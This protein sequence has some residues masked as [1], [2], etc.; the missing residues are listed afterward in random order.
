[1]TRRFDVMTSIG[2]QRR[3]RG[4]GGSASDRPLPVTTLRTPVRLRKPATVSAAPA[5]S[6]MSA[7]AGQPRTSLVWTETPREPPLPPIN[8]VVEGSPSASSVGPT[9]SIS[10]SRSTAPRGVQASRTRCMP[11]LA[12][13]AARLPSPMAALP[14]ANGRCPLPP[15]PARGAGRVG[16]GP[17]TATGHLACA[18][19]FASSD[20]LSRWRR[21]PDQR[22]STSRSAP[23]YLQQRTAGGAGHQVWRRRA[24]R[25]DQP[26]AADGFLQH[27]LGCG[28][29][30]VVAG[31]RGDA[32]RIYPRP[33][34][35]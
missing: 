35:G 34:R 3:D 29:A 31:D 13:A 11:I 4:P 7:R 17:I 30:P 2:P 8:G 10:P 32:H 16:K 20:G 9:S 12:G 22:P 23:R 1:M 18:M 21:G 5:D 24:L 25:C 28:Q 14:P 15:W 33:A 6:V 26:R 27:L 19:T